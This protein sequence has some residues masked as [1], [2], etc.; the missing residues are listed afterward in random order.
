MVGRAVGAVVLMLFA[1]VVN[2]DEGARRESRDS[3]RLVTPETQLAIRTGLS[4]L[5]GQQAEDGAFDGAF[6]YHKNVGVAGLCGLAFLASGSTSGRGP[7]GRTVDRTLDYIISRAQPEGFISEDRAADRYHGP[8]YGHGFA[9][10]FLAEAYGTH[11]RDDVGVVLRRAVRLIVDTQSEQGGWRYNPQPEVADI[12]VTVC[13]VMALRAA[14]NGGI[15][16]PKETIDRAVDY[17]LRSQNNDGGFKYQLLRSAESR[18]PRSAAALVALYNAGIHEGDA[19]DRGL[20]YLMEYR[21]GGGRRESQHYYYGHYYAVQ[22]AWHSRGPIWEAW[23][24]AIRDEL[25]RTQETDGGWSDPW[26]GRE[27]ATAMALLV[28]QTPNNLLPIFE[29]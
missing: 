8:M 9:T 7:Y 1:A 19:I 10:L 15:S 20:S 29:R 25:I 17:I 22:A 16:V 27:Y 14:R 3:R 4:W 24:P 11:P 26:I 23:Y 5:A 6:N 28:L 12:S 13:Q 21:P 2:A 18:F